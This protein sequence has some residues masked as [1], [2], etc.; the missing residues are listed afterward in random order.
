MA[1]LIHPDIALVTQHSQFAWLKLAALI[2]RLC[3]H[4]A[5]SITFFALC[6]TF[7]QS[8]YLNRIAN[9]HH[10]F[11]KATYLPA[12]TYILVTSLFNEWNYLSA[13]LVANWL[14]LAMLSSSLRLYNAVDARKQI[15]N[16]GAY[17]SLASLLI[18]PH[19]AFVLL[20]LMALASLRP[21]KASEWMVALLG[22][23]TPFYFIA[24]IFYLT[25]SL[26]QYKGMFTLGWALPQQIDSPEVVLVGFSTILILLCTGAFYLNVHMGRMLMQ[27]KKWWWVIIMMLLVGIV[28]GLFTIARNHNQWM[29][30]LIPATFVIANLWFEERKKW[31][32]TIFFYFLAVVVIFVQ[33]FPPQ[34]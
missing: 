3:G 21:F 17:I 14:L 4:S 2:E 26:S 10:L 31:I 15:F 7:G 30:F 13:P 12:M 11:P 24:G 23:I 1:I 27:C 34:P 29:A 32:G 19:I 9:R 8:I 33:W 6:N 22:I 16:I 18:F 25:D 28:A 20:L 5:F